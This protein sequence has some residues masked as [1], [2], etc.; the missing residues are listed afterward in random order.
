ML[1]YHR[2]HGKDCHGNSKLTDLPI[3]RDFFT[4]TDVTCEADSISKDEYVQLSMDYSE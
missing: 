2:N 4:D 1:S 3:V